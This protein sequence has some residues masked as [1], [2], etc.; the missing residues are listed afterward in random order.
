MDTADVVIIGAGPAGL[1]AARVLKA[2]GVASLVVLDREQEAGGVPRH[3]GHP[4][5]GLYEFRRVLTGPA[6]ARKLREAAAGIDIRTGVTVTRLGEGGLLS[7]VTPAGEDQIRARRV[8]LATGTRE[9]PRSARLVSGTRPQG[10]MTTGTLQQ[11]VLRGVRPVRRAVVV[12]TELVSFSALLTLHDAGI[13]VAAMIEE[14]ARITFQRPADLFPRL[15]LG[16]PVLLNTQ[17]IAIEGGERV[18]A[19]LIRRGGGHEERIPCDGVIFTG[20]YIPENALLKHSHLEIT[21]GLGAPSIDQT[22]RCSDGVVY[23]AGNVLRPVETAGWAYREGEAAAAMIAASLKTDQPATRS[24]PITW[25]API[26]IVTPQRI[27]L[28]GPA[29]DAMQFKLRVSR[30]AVGRLRLLIDGRELWSRHMEALP[31]RRIDLPR[32]LPSLEGA[33]R[34]HIAFQEI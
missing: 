22:Y 25:D 13:Q 19:V 32:R 4:P 11:Y 10:V 27:S 29:L 24:I 14:N 34:I 6:Y 12:G 30:Q 33:S 26:T 3:C 31:E 21:P 5:F 20:Q 28:P 7:I 15:V 1:A 9:T 2:R 18:E 17:I 8:L 16:V 23:A